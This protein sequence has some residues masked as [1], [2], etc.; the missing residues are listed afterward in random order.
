MDI[1]KTIR[2]R[3]TV[4][5]FKA[6]PVDQ[7]LIL[8]LLDAAARLYE[9]E[10]PPHWR[11]VHF[12]SPES[13]QKLGNSMMAKVRD[14]N[15]GKLI[16]S[17][18][19]DL[20][21]KQVIQTPVNLV[22]IAES[23]DN[24]QKSDENYAAV[25]SIMQNFQLLGWEHSLGML[26]YTEPM[27]QHDAFYK[28][29]GLRPG[30]R[31]AGILHIGHIDKSPKGW[32]K[33]T[34]AVKKWT[35]MEGVNTQHP[36]RPRISPQSVLDILNVAVWAPNDG[37]REPWRFVY[38][39]EDEAVRKIGALEGDAA[40]SYLLVV[41]KEEK[42]AFKREEDYAAICCLIQNFQLLAK[43]E[44]WSVRRMIPEWTYEPERITSYGIL[45]Q[46]RIV[47]VLAL[48]GSPRQ[49]DTAP[50]ATAVHYSCI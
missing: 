7:E 30:E 40:A 50:N 38:V 39:T 20:F 44:P 42:D 5:K 17:K 19:L 16:P 29:I 35:F 36:D 8:S 28:A 3:R 37:L 12:S 1:S 46:E 24:R 18:M 6:A 22:F 31:F 9:S 32:R 14:S 34:P 43:L 25:C 47:A 23:A 15:L 10:A 27:I 48:G 33:R 49:P 4:R 41:A 2:E 11:C 21:A 26:W 13:R 45:P